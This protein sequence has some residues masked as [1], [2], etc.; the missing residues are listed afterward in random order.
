VDH[1]KIGPRG[2]LSL[3]SYV[4]EGEIEMG[5]ISRRD[6]LKM[7]GVGA[8]GT[9]LAAC[10]P[11]TTAQPTTPP[12]TV[13]TVASK[14]V[15]IVMV[16]SWFS[17]TQDAAVL[18]EV[19][20]IISDK[21]KSEGLNIEI[22]SM[23]LDDHQTKYPL[24]YSSGADFTMAFDAPW[25]LMDT[26]RI[27]GSLAIMDD[28]FNQY[29]TKLKVEVTDKILNA[30]KWDGHWY[31]LPA[32]PQYGLTTGVVLRKDLLDKYGAPE[33][34]PMTGWPSLEPFLAAVA[35]N[36]PNIIPFAYDLGLPPMWEGAILKRTMGYWQGVNS[37]TG[38]VIPDFSKSRTLVDYETVQEVIDTTKLMRSWWEKGYLP[39]ADL[40]ISGGSVGTDYFFPGKAAAFLTN[41][42]NYDYF[43]FQKTIA[44]SV[45]DAVLK[46]Y[47]MSGVQAGR[48]KE[49]GQLVQGNFIVFN[50]SAPKEQLVAATQFF[51][52][53]V[54]NQDNVDLWLLGVD[55]KNYK[56]ESNLRF[57]EIP[58]VDQAKNFRR[59]FYVGGISA[60]MNRNSS[61]LP[62]DVL[63]YIAWRMDEKN[64]DFDPY[65]S[66][67]VDTKQGD[68]QNQMAKLQ[69]SWAEAF[70]GMSSGQTPADDSFAKMKKTL[71]D[72]GRQ[73]YK[74]AVQKQLDDFIAAHPA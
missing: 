70:H 51:E 61:D 71:D 34:D 9:V 40:P 21:M 35:K 17:V 10:T 1:H 13:S 69:A 31:G 19:N 46:G 59:A 67:Y 2:F 44:S 32:F 11:Q 57:S 52:W 15:K 22:E 29:G 56:K 62:D 48:Y 54:S 7:I 74:T 47:D 33:P 26:L 49:V 43:S 65:E 14:P 53:L 30:N 45:P 25:N 12:T 58:G 50:G 39:K 64:F 36:D 28:Y 24:L 5:K 20:K 63:A 41:Q 27:Q 18:N 37:K 72:A 6:M 66:F 16:E 3:D 55:G 68:I 60:A 23:V 42:P 8:A 73:P 4:Q 38:I